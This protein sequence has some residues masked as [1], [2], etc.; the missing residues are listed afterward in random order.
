MI[1]LNINETSPEGLK[2]NALSTALDMEP[3]LLASAL[4]QV[5]CSRKQAA[6][7]QAGA[8]PRENTPQPASK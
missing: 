2:L 3:S 8:E 5:A 4:I 7:Q 1:T 6:R